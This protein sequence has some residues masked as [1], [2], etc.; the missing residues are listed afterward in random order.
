MKTIA[1]RM[2]AIPNKHSE[3][4]IRFAHISITVYAICN[5]NE[6]ND[7]KEIVIGIGNR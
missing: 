4:V 3:V 2:R 1:Y 6:L 5:S 7:Q